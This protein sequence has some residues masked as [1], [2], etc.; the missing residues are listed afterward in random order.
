MW[1]HRFSRP[2][3]DV[4]FVGL[5]TYALAASV[6]EA[7][8]HPFWYDEIFTVVLGRLPSFSETLDALRSAADTSGLAYYGV[9]RLFADI[10]TSPELAF[11]LPSVLANAVSMVAI[12]IFARRDL[13]APAGLVAVMVM[14]LSRMFH[15]YSVEARPY[16]LMIMWV[17]LA[18]LSWQRA[19]HKGWV[20][21]L[22]CSL[23]L[24]V[25]THYYAVFGAVAVVIAELVRWVRTRQVRIGVWVA[26]STAPAALAWVWPILANLR[27]YYGPNYFSKPTLGK[28]MATYDWALF[29]RPG[30]GFGVALGLGLAMLLLFIRLWPQ[31]E[32]LDVQRPAPE[33]LALVMA[34]LAS[35]F[36]VLG[37]TVLLNGGFAE[38]Y[39]LCMLAGLGL[40][41]AYGIRA[42]DDRK[43]LFA[44]SGLA[45]VLV[46]HE[47][48]FWKA[49]GGVNGSRSSS[50]EASIEQALD[51]VSDLNVPVVIDNGLDFVPWAF[52]SANKYPRER[53]L[54]LTDA[55]AARLY[56]GTDSIDLDLELLRKYTNLNVVDFAS[57]RQ[58]HREFYL[59]SGSGANSWWPT[60][61]IKD[62][63]TVTLVQPGSRH[64]LFHV[65][66]PDKASG[67]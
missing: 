64:S 51:G 57:F 38:R 47:A 62:Q 7:A 56:T 60:R 2:V 14:L 50:A 54:Y 46:A 55:A 41:V 25:T 63:Y 9:V 6:W 30:S 61:L 33:T 15:G 35:P 44:V 40:S 67:P 13:G 23:A 27:D 1:P 52:Y 43:Q 3:A 11:R 16:A 4:S 39:A 48:V 66:A 36:I 22:G 58:G 26:L 29:M 65:R 34:L 8:S 20:V 45:C 24:A 59:V 17:C 53:L 18:A 10:V 28:A 31:D 37:A 49:G 19:G 5:V 42:L 12:Y 32:R 21:A